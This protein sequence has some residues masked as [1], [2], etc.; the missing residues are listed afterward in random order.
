MPGRKGT[1]RHGPG[2]AEGRLAVAGCGCSFRPGT[3]SANIPYVAVAAHI[4]CRHGLPMRPAPSRFTRSAP[5]IALAL[6]VAFPLATGGPL[7]PPT[8]PLALMATLTEAGTELTWHAPLRNG[9][10]PVD[11]YRVY[12][13]EHGVRELI[14]NTTSTSYTDPIAPDGNLTTYLV[15][16][17]SA[18]GESLPSNPALPDYPHCPVVYVT[19]LPFPGI[20]LMEGCLFPLPVDTPVVRLHDD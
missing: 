13:V 2:D 8:P 20:I 6:L 3:Q 1:A 4:S 9:T 16:A 14:A 10:A 7:D 15:T 19:I 12:R 11:Y 18:V 5:A 17:V